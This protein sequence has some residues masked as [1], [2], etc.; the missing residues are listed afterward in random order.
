MAIFATGYATHWTTSSDRLNSAA[1]W[2]AIAGYLFLLCV[3][4]LARPRWITAITAVVLATPILASSLFLPLGGL[5]H[6][7]PRRIQP[8]GDN[9]YASWQTFVELGPS[10]SGVDVDIFYRPPLLP[11]LRHTRLS[12]RFY[13]RRCQGAATKVLLQPDRSSVFVRC[14]AWPGSVDATPG[15]YL[16]L[17]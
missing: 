10:S 5:F 7:S 13:D 6:P 9:L 2:S 14:P 15:D 16:R 1:Y 3:H 11:F 8:L 12:G 4:S 17:H